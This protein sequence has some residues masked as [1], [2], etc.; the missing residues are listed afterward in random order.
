MKLDIKAFGLATGILWG[1]SLIIMGIAGMIWPSYAADF[2]NA[3]G[4]KYIGY[5]PTVLGSLIGGAWGFVDAGIAGLVLAW[6]YN[7]FAR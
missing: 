2:V 7:K 4:T 6:L 3:V 5:A 1:L